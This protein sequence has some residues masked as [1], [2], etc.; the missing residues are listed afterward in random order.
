M[1]AA[2][3]SAW[4]RDTNG[5]QRRSECTGALIDGRPPAYLFRRG[6]IHDGSAAFFFCESPSL[7]CRSPGCDGTEFGRR[8]QAFRRG[9]VTASVRASRAAGPRDRDVRACCS[10]RCL[11]QVATP[12]CARRFAIGGV[13]RAHHLRTVVPSMP[14]CRQADVDSDMQ[15]APTHLTSIINRNTR[16]VA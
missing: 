3:R 14:M 8:L 7:L 2:P 12:N 10:R 6:R 16:A 5:G 9:L 1:A 11:R 15:P 13:G 4:P